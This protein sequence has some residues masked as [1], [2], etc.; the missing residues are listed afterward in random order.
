MWTFCTVFMSSCFYEEDITVSLNISD[1]ILFSGFHTWDWGG[2]IANKM[3]KID[4]IWR[5]WLQICGQYVLFL[6][7]YHRNSKYLRLHF[8]R[9]IS[10]VKLRKK[11]QKPW[12]TANESS[13]RGWHPI[14]SERS[15]HSTA[16]MMTLLST[17]TMEILVSCLRKTSGSCYV[18]IVLWNSHLNVHDSKWINPLTEFPIHSC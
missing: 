17:S 12:N 1:Y 16:T 7:G 3:C 11:V 4:M 13:F 2:C 14:P 6:E 9:W 5:I 8:V 15:S 10:L 18:C